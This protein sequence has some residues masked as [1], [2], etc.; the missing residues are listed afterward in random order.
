VFEE[1]AALGCAEKAEHPTEVVHSSE[2]M[3]ERKECFASK[4]PAKAQS[5]RLPRLQTEARAQREGK[6]TCKNSFRKLSLD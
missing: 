6:P 2:V 1:L 4:E 3:H 5:R